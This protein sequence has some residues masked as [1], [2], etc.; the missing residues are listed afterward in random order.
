LDPPPDQSVQGLEE[1]LPV[2]ALIGV[3]NTL[4]HPTESILHLKPSSGF[5]RT[6]NKPLVDA[7]K[8]G[9][10]NKERQGYRFTELALR[11]LARDLPEI[12]Q[13]TEFSE[14]GSELLHKYW[15][16]SGY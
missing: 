1:G 9:A 4:H 13:A 12:V 15:R 10:H 11:K 2:S 6:V 3:D 8:N 7:F 5:H 16:R 14:A